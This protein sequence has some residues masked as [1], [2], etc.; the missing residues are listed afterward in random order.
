MNAITA[1]LDQLHAAAIERSTEAAAALDAAREARAAL[2]RA[3][4]L[5]AADDVAVA[6]ADQRLALAEQVAARAGE[7]VAI[8]AA[9][10]DARRAA[11]AEA[12]ERRRRDMLRRHAEDRMKAAAKIEAALVALTDA[13]RELV[14]ADRACTTVSSAVQ[15]LRHTELAAHV[16]LPEALRGALAV[17]GLTHLATG[18]ERELRATPFPARAFSPE[19]LLELDAE[20]AR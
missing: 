17:G 7:R 8:L 2:V 5:G 3:A 15:V 6:D 13:T 18:Q 1:D 4:A 11:E 9:E 14:A 20:A 19:H 10:I 12:A 16:R